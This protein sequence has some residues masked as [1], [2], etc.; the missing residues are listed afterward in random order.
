MVKLKREGLGGAWNESFPGTATM[1]ED[2]SPIAILYLCLPCGEETGQKQ[3]VNKNNRMEGLLKVPKESLRALELTRGCSF[4][5][6]CWLGN[7]EA[8]NAKSG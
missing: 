8:E 1:M 5:P 3:K 2:A 7:C 6:G 4:L